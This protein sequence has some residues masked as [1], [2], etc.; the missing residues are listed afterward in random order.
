MP[1]S[2][3]DSST[4]PTVR[5]LSQ[6]VGKKVTGICHDNGADPTLGGEKIYGL[7]FDDETVAW[8]LADPEGNGPEHLDIQKGPG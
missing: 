3:K 5:H 1:N 8:I 2:N 4:D 6:L 7:V